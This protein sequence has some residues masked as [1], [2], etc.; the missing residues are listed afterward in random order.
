MKWI[1][2]VGVVVAL[3]VSPTRWFILLDDSSGATIEVTCGRQVPAPPIGGTEP[4]LLPP[5]QISAVVSHPA[6]LP[7]GLTATGRTVDLSGVDVGA[8]VKVKG[9]VGVFRGEKQVSLER[10]CTIFYLPQNILRSPSVSLSHVPLHTLRSKINKL[11][12]SNEP[13]LKIA[14]LISS[15]NDELSAWAEISSFRES[16]LMIP[17]VIS[18][19]DE[20]RARRKAEGVEYEQKRKSERQE[21]KE[22]KEKKL[23]AE[24]RQRKQEKKLE[25]ERKARKDAERHSHQA[26]RDEREVPSETRKKS[27]PSRN[28]QSFAQ[29]TTKPK[30]GGTE[31]EE[32]DEQEPE[33]EPH[34]TCRFD[35]LGF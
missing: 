25:V 5:A 28:R 15:T 4:N 3:D 33:P 22:R 7:I 16:I 1:R 35:A 19:Q 23:R 14:A 2:L 30:V 12:L 34:P 13:Y 18:L 27:M 8:V 6:P 26:K 11:Y 24:V 17:W 31:R 29:E 20:R 32:T 21:R 10:I 9:G